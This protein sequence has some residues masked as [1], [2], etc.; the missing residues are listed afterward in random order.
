MMA[1]NRQSICIDA[2]PVQKGDVRANGGDLRDLCG[3]ETQPGSPFTANRETVAL[4]RRVEHRFPVMILA[5]RSFRIAIAFALLSGATFSIADACPASDEYHELR[6]QLAEQQAAITQQQDQINEL[7]RIVSEQAR[8]LGELQSAS[9][10]RNT[11]PKPENAYAAPDRSA[12]PTSTGQPAAPAPEASATQI[13]LQPG[14]RPLTITPTG[15]L[16]YSQVWRSKNVDSG[17]PTNFAAI[18]FADTVDGHRRQ[19]LSSSAYTRLG[20]QINGS[21]PPCGSWAWSKPTLSD[22]SPGTSRRHRTPRPAT[23]AARLRRY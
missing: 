23:V 21:F 12:P 4:G 20:L 7:R 17:L 14:C 11:P 8:M 5:F 22:S 1:A 19:T 3:Q 13:P 9:P 2:V 18:P 16:E 15:Y 10:A 6:G